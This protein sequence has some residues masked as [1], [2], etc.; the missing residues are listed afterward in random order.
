MTLVNLIFLAAMSLSVTS[1]AIADTA[2]LTESD[3]SFRIE[4]GWGFAFAPV[5]VKVYP[6]DGRFNIGLGLLGVSAGYD[7]TPTEH[8]VISTGAMYI[9]EEAGGPYVGVTYHLNG[10]GNSGLYV[11]FQ[12]AVILDDADDADSLDKDDIGTMLTLGYTF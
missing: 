11:G 3:K 12:S 6:N 1:L 5:G 8:L 2:D 9:L 4:T 7:F 10:Y